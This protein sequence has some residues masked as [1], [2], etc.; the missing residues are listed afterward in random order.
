MAADSLWMSP[1]YG[2]DSVAIHFTWKQHVDAVDALTRAL[3]H[4][5]LPLGA[6]PHWGKLLH[7]GADRIA[8]LY[9][10][11]SEFRALADACDP[12]G[13]FRNAF[14]TEHVFG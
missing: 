10:R 12:T 13:K 5:L 1:S 9:P 6:R 7:A 4:V 14:L 11:L 3:E 2:R 8:P